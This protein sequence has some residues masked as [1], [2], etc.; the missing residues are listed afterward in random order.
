M[1]RIV[2]NLGWTVLL[3]VSVLEAS[4][5]HAPPVNQAFR[6]TVPGTPGLPA[7]YTREGVT[8]DSPSSLMAKTN[9][10]IAASMAKVQVQPAPLGSLRMIL[11]VRTPLNVQN[12]KNPESAAVAGKVYADYQRDIDENHLVALRKANIFSPIHASTEQVGVADNDGADFALWFNNGHWQL[13]YRKGDTAQINDFFDMAA[14]TTAV[15]N[16]A[17]NALKDDASSLKYTNTT[18]LKYTA[19]LDGTVNDKPRFYFGSADYFSAADMAPAMKAAWI[20]AADQ[21]KPVA[22]P[23]GRRVKIVLPANPRLSV[24]NKAVTG[25]RGDELR[26]AEKDF[27]AAIAAGY[28]QAI[29]N[30][31]LFAEIDIVTQDVSDVP[32][33]SYDATIW[34]PAESPFQWDF[35]VAGQKDARILVWPPNPEMQDWVNALATQMLTAP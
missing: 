4:C 27:I 6:I 14:W 7:T 8:Y 26:Q 20:R 16:F 17:H 11:P 35:R 15:N 3:A 19:H 34:R 13:R 31:H 18:S 23:V 22:R 9:E 33:D 10:E 28:I 2:K 12:D 29:R 32:L 21:V 5:A 30:G 24:V 1:S 25:V